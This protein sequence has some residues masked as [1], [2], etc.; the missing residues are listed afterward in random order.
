ME[1]FN[2]G[3]V[4]LNIREFQ[5]SPKTN[6]NHHSST[7]QFTTVEKKLNSATEDDNMRQ[8]HSRDPH[9]SQHAYSCQLLYLRLKKYRDFF[10]NGASL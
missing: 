4:L 1:N 10:E 6:T 8:R 3:K 9:I 2:R 7:Q 5:H